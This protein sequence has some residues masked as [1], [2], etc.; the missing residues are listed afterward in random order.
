MLNACPEMPPYHS[1]HVEPLDEKFLQPNFT[2]LSACLLSRIDTIKV[3]SEK[4]EI[5][6]IDDYE[7]YLMLDSLLDDIVSLENEL[8]KISTF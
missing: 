8:L 4:K 1:K 5:Y 2:D 7:M 3:E 6:D